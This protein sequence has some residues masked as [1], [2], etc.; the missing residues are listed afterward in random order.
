MTGEQASTT[1]LAKHITSFRNKNNRVALVECLRLERDSV[2][3]VRFVEG[4]WRLLLAVGTGDQINHDD[5]R[6]LT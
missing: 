1:N 6:G 4:L 2:T 3:V 5:T